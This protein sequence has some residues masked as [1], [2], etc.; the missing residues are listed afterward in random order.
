MS[1]ATLGVSTGPAFA[2][3][4]VGYYSNPTASPG[5]LVMINTPTG[6]R[7]IFNEWRYVP[8]GGAVSLTHFW[9]GFN[10]NA[11]PGV[12]VSWHDSKGGRYCAITETQLPG[13]TTLTLTCRNS[14]GAWQNIQP[15]PGLV[16]DAFSRFTLSET[17]LDAVLQTPAGGNEWWVYNGSWSLV[18]ITLPNGAGKVTMDSSGP[19]ACAAWADTVNQEV[20]V[21]CDWSGSRIN[22]ASPVLV[23]VPAT[24]LRLVWETLLTR[25]FATFR[26]LDTTGSTTTNITLPNGAQFAGPPP[27]RLLLATD[28]EIFYSNLATNAVHAWSVGSDRF[29]FAWGLPFVRELH[30]SDNKLWALDVGVGDPYIIYP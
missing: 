28:A 7:A 18:N 25:Q 1:V 17:V 23:F 6:T 20:L 5:P 24:N 4:I 9:N 30:V 12:H 14:A 10:W 29:I 27:G 13:V 16:F 8:M 22:G 26:W 11:R 19:A 3:E 21:A 15:P 2:D